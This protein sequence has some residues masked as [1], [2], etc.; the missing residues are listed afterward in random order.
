MGRSSI[1]DEGFV[2]AEGE[3]GFMADIVTG[4]MSG[5]FWVVGDAVFGKFRCHWEKLQG[6][7]TGAHVEDYAMPD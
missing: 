2:G 3:A 6:M 1:D 7:R 5:I 4:S